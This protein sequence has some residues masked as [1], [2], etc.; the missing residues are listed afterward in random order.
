MTT[1]TVEIANT[2]TIQ[3]LLRGI[4]ALSD[5]SIKKLADYIDD[6][7]DEQ[8]EAED[9]AYIDSLT[10]EDYANAIPENEVIAEYEAKYGP[11]G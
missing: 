8:A 3:S 7:I 11:L 6:L 9:I 4:A 5:E 10:P 1:Q 2:T